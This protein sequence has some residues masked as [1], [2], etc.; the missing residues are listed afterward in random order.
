MKQL[1][2]FVLIIVFFVAGIFI[3]SKAMAAD[4]A[5]IIPPGEYLIIPGK[6]ENYGMVNTFAYN[7]FQVYRSLEHVPGLRL[8]EGEFIVRLNPDRKPIVNKVLKDFSQDYRQLTLS[9][10]RKGLFYPLRPLKIG[11]YCRKG[12]T[13]GYLWHAYPLEKCQMDIVFF[14]ENDLE[15]LKDVDVICFPSGGMYRQN[16]S[17]SGQDWLKWLIREQGVGY[18][19]TCGGNVFGCK[20]K[21]LDAMLVRSKQ[22]HSYGIGINGYPE[23][24]VI[25]QN[26]PAMI[27]VSKTTHPFYYSGQAFNRVG[28]DV[29]VLTT[30]NQ[31]NNC[32]TFDGTAY[33]GEV[34]RGMLNRPGMVTGQYGSGRVILSGPH[35]EVGEEQLFVDWIYYL[36]GDGIG[37]SGRNA[38]NLTTKDTKIKKIDSTFFS[39]LVSQIDEFEKL[40]KPYEAK[41]RPYYSQRWKSGITAGLPI[42]LIFV[43]TYDRLKHITKSLSFFGEDNSIDNEMAREL[44]EICTQCEIQISS[45]R[46]DFAALIP[47][48]ESA[49][50]MLRD[51]DQSPLD[52]KEI[53]KKRFYQEYYKKL[54]PRMKAFNLTFVRLDHYLRQAQK[55][56]MYQL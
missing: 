35:P 45:L 5:I 7:G 25:A 10:A 51:I 31:F 49:L 6:Y 37:S 26:H 40:V 39:P 54:I 15:Q 11:I 43:D 47:H 21:L 56:L 41:I 9:K 32:F 38:I 46:T 28:P 19:G 24:K 52:T 17:Q 50:K 18:L 48:L 20:L 14:T 13:A 44:Q 30:Y 29:T 3:F 34:H 27:S 36:A 1:G 4:A 55:V 16:I 42:L 33:H 8:S 12:V 53:L 2:S 23:M 22:G